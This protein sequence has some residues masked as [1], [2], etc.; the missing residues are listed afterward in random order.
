MW[1]FVTSVIIS[2]SNPK[3][4]FL[5]LSQRIDATLLLIVLHMS[6]CHC[7]FYATHLGMVMEGRWGSVWKETNDSKLNWE[8]LSCFDYERKQTELELFCKSIG[9][10]DWA[11]T[12]FEAKLILFEMKFSGTRKE[13]CYVVFKVEPAAVL[14]ISVGRVKTCL[15][16][17]TFQ[18]ILFVFTKSFDM[19]GLYIRAQSRCTLHTLLLCTKNIFCPLNAI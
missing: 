13:M 9:K 10:G 2:G 4:Q 8:G 15:P 3:F 5:I 14:Y 11:R 12:H 18:I 19:Y 1:D 7:T 17:A 6:I 16:K